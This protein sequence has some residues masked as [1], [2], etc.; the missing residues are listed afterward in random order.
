MLAFAPGACA[1][2]LTKQERKQLIQHLKESEKMLKNATKG[3][4]LEQ[5][6]FKAAP[7]KWSV[8][9]CVEHLTLAEEVGLEFMGDILKSPP[10]KVK[11]GD[12]TFYQ[13]NTDRSKKVQAPD[14]LRPTGQW[15]DPKKLLKEFSARRKKT[16]EFVETTQED[17]RGH[18]FGGF[19][20]YQAVLAAA[21]HTERHVAQM[22][23]VKTDPHFP[24]K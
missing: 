3:L 4:S 23:E 22:R 13:T 14:V 11:D 2:T 20:G 7:D 10:G 18:V 19:D 21:A 16:I 9:E 5:W 6:R 15:P 1:G 24:R 8:Q 17:L 12:D